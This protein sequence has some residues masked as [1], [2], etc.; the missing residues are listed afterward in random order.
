MRNRRGFTLVELLVVIAII[1]VLI[2]LLL[3]A[4]QKAR[5]AA[6]RISCTNNLHQLGLG[7]HN[8]AS[9]FGFLPSEYIPNPGQQSMAPTY[10]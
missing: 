4:V 6:S 2:G 9:A 3:P 8:F 5:E 1:S 7:A 10:P